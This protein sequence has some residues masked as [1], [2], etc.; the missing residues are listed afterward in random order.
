MTSRQIC[1]TLA[2]L[3]VLATPSAAF[4]VAPPTVLLCTLPSLHCRESL[5][6]PLTDTRPLAECA[7]C[8]RAAAAAAHLAGAAASHAPVR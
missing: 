6:D 7:K 1:S 3:A 5:S 2:A 8:S 4:I